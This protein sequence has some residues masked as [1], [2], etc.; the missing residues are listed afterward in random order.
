MKDKYWAKNKYS[1]VDPVDYEMARFQTAAGKL[2][3]ETEKK[4]VSE[5]IRASTIPRSSGIN[6]LDVATGPGRL[7]FY[8]E[9]QF[10]NATITGMDVNQNMLAKAESTAVREKS[11]VTFVQGDIYQM[12]FK[13]NQFDIVAGLRFSMHLPDIDSLLKELARILQKDGILIFDIFN[14]TS[15]LS[16]KSLRTGSR[17]RSGGWY[18]VSDMIDFSFRNG[19]EFVRKKG[20]FL[21]GETPVRKFP[22]KLLFMISVSVTPPIFLQDFS[23][24]I[25]LCFRKI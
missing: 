18:T 23:T 15:I 8:L 3:D 25:V 22:E 16:V 20:I 24:K 17:G 2:I 10:K 1:K 9:K 21:F 13:D 4:A 6:I 5:L 11:K 7:A 14:M 19:L 12:P